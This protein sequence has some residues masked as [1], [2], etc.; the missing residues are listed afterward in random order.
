MERWQRRAAK[1]L[2]GVAV[3]ILVVSLLYHNAMAFVEG[4]SQ[5]YFHSTQVVIETFTGTGY[6]SDSPW[7]TPLGNLFVMVMDLSTFLFLFIVFPYVFQPILEQSLSRTVPRSVELEDHVVVCGYSARGE[8][9]IDELETRDVDYVVIVESRDE[10]LDLDD[11]GV[12]VI[13]G[14]PDNVETL[15]RAAVDAATSVVVDTS[16]EDAA[17][18]VLAVRECAER[19]QV[20][21]LCQDPALERPLR[22]AGADDVMT[23][24]HLLAQ[25]ITERIQTELNPR[26]SDVTSLG[27]DFALVEI[28]VFEDSPI[29][30]MT[31][32]EAGLIDNQSAAIVGLWAG[33]EFVGS[34]APDTV[35]TDETT[36]LVAGGERE[37]RDLEARTYA[38]HGRNGTV[39]IAGHGEV[40]STVSEQLRATDVDCTVVDVEE[41]AG[42][43]VVGNATDEDVLREAVIEDAT[44]FVVA[45]KDDAAAILSV[46]VAR[47][48]AP[49]LDIIVRMN[50]ADNEVK[51]RRA[52][53]DYV[54][55]LPDISG[56]LL[57]LD[58]LREEIVSY[59]RQLKIVRFESPALTGRTVADIPLAETNCT[60]IAVERSGEVYPDASPTFTLE[61]G[62]S[63][64]LAGDDDAIN[65]FESAV[66]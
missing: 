30:G 49:D 16:D 7:E 21:A 40:G 62:D 47:E 23:P 6:G 50:D 34:P 66:E 63:L 61:A 51:A 53:A 32:A 64:L 27:D 10:V 9:L 22:Y 41:K 4:R 42:V 5:S 29:C 60:L 18:T 48:L 45:I 28:T 39:V 20:V 12:S 36:L 3:L 31:L 57:A 33:G 38:S 2:G 25:R 44:T 24:R 55:T 37:L 58:V 1:T 46:L 65:A 19:I 14:D 52:G 35:I 13:H 54:L 59:D 8:R 11:A 43:D 15:E 26:L 17:S 56:R